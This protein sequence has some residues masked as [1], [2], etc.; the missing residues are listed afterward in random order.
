M[1]RFGLE[2]VEQLLVPINY[3]DFNAEDSE[4]TVNLSVGG[5]DAW[6]PSKCRD[7]KWNVTNQEMTQVGF[8]CL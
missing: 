6:E 3:K 4:V 8:C 5:P 2:L 7:R 1:S